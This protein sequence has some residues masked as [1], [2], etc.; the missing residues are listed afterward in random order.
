VTETRTCAA[1][2]CENPVPARI[3]RG[4]PFTYCTVCRPP[5]ERMHVTTSLVAEIDHVPTTE[6]VRPAGRIWIVRLRRGTR[7]VTVAE[8]LG[9]PSADHLV[10]QINELIGAPSAP[11]ILEDQDSSNA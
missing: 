3:G 10:R 4:R 11:A 7:S 5:K 6:N 9:R 2:G 8:E 1:K